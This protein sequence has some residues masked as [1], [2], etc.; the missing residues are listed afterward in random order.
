VFSYLL[1][2]LVFG[3]VYAIAS[4]SLTAA[5][6]ATGTMNFA[7]GALAYLLARAYY[8]F[9]SEHGWNVLAAGAL[10]I[11]VIAPALGFVLWAALFRHLMHAAT[12]VQVVATVGLSVATLP[13]AAL[14]FGNASVTVAPGFAPSPPP[15]YDV[16][17]VPITLDQ[18]L[19]LAVV[20]A[21][22]A[23]GWAFLRFTRAGLR[24]RALVD[25]QELTSLA[26][27]NPQVVAVGVW[28]VNT[29]LAALAGVLLSPLA[30]LD[31][32][33]Y[34]LVTAAAF[35]AVV[36]ARLDNVLVAFLVALALGVATGLAQDLM[37]PSSTIYRDIV[38]SL[39]FVFV[40]I[41]GVLYARSGR[42]ADRRASL[43]VLA[44]LQI[45]YERA[46]PATGEGRFGRLYR[47]S[48]DDW[49]WIAPIAVVAALPLVLSGLW[50]QL[51]GLGAVYA[52]AFLSYTLLTGHAGVI[53]LCQITFAGIGAI[54]AAQLATNHGWPVLAAVLA[55]GLIA[56][57][58][59]FLLGL[60]TLHL[61]DIYVALVTLTFGLFVENLIFP[62]NIFFQSG[63]GVPIL[64]PG[65]LSGTTA[66]DYFALA[67][68]VVIALGL[69][70]YRRSTGGLALSAVRWSEPG[71]RSIGLGVAWSKIM[72][73]C[74]AAFIAGLAGAMLALYSGVALTSDFATLLGL[75]WLSVLVM[76]GSRTVIAALVAGMTFAFIPALIQ[77]YLPSSWGNVPTLLFG[78]GA[79]EVA[80]HPAGFLAENRKNILA[81]YRRLRVP[82]AAAEELPED[83]M[84]RTAK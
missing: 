3:G 22:V 20:A 28:V 32:N 50:V 16:F 6:R 44:K 58:I 51:V 5:Y 60:L 33:A 31:P 12:L 61:G 23:A 48:R 25:S 40:V 17:G 46:R 56:V 11:V 74:V 47:F 45:A 81:L 42:V 37:N 67:L 57:P 64:K 82:P 62:L 49:A 76:N 10:V 29:V 30:G 54:T 8:F 52:A 18:V 34:T 72:A 39:P 53:S 78:L 38:P 43:A 41:F 24:V 36:A 2:G 83:L 19:V 69:T 70:A 71:A 68:F 80:R 35:A 79:I 9:N 59:G 27:V 13:V 75:V 7:F 4:V 84:V 55:G 63:N 77:T 21:V 1:A 66:F 26:G 65:F 15:T 14:L 73:C